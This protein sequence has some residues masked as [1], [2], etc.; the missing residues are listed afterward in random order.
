MA[1]VAVV[2]LLVLATA[3]SS[4]ADGNVFFSDDESETFDLADL[5]DGETRTFGEGEDQITAVR[6]GDVVR[7]TGLRENRVPEI[8]CN[9]VTDSCKVI[10]VNG[11]TET[12]I[13]VNKRRSCDDGEDCETQDVHRVMIGHG[14]HVESLAQGQLGTWTEAVDC[15]GDEDCSALKLHNVFIGRVPVGEPG[16]LTWTQRIECEGEDDCEDVR[17]ILD[18]DVDLSAHGDLMRVM[19]HEVKATLRCPEG[20]TTM[21]LSP[22]DADQVYLCPKHSLPL[23]KVEHHSR[24]L[25]RIE[26]KGEPQEH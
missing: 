21:V 12:M 1:A 26:L 8:T 25:K 19:L 15:D 5:Y 23:E 13:L 3:G 9:V 4:L 16:E 18:G 7:L 22:E 17:V 20:D 6:E 10:S 2:A 24:R 11:G 14:A